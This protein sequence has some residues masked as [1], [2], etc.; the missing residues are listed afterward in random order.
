MFLQPKT[1]TF[2][3]CYNASYHCLLVRQFFYI[4]IV[5]KLFQKVLHLFHS[6]FSSTTAPTKNPLC[7]LRTGNSWTKSLL[8]RKG[9]GEFS[10][11]ERVFKINHYEWM[12][13]ILES[14]K[15]TSIIS[16]IIIHQH[17]K[18]RHVIWKPRLEAL[19]FNVAPSWQVK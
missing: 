4:D 6:I 15:Y 9:E 10:N 16:Y 11:G 2:W 13:H 7:G 19:I 5:L 18:S 8:V 12:C 1:G 14:I 3:H 17:R